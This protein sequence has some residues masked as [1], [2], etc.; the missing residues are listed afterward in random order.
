[1]AKALT[2]GKR[3]VTYLLDGRRDSNG[4]EFLLSCQRPFCDRDNGT[5]DILSGRFVPIFDGCRNGQ[6]AFD[7]DRLTEQLRYL[8]VSIHGIGEPFVL[9][10]SNA[11]MDS[12]H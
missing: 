4:F 7:D 9:N 10:G 1:M 3:I 11:G 12:Q 6:A 5:F 2:F 8:V